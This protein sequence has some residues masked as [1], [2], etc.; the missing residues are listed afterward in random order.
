MT[1]LLESFKLG[2]IGHQGD[3]CPFCPPPDK[4]DHY[5]TYAGDK[6]NGGTLG[7]LLDESETLGVGGTIETEARPKDRKIGKDG[8]RNQYPRKTETQTEV[9]GSDKKWSFQAHHAIP[10]KQCLAKSPV[11]NFILE[12][13]RIRYDTG[14]SVN[15][16]QN[17]I[18]LPSMPLNMP[19]PDRNDPQGKFDLAQEAMAKFDRQF[20]LGHHAINVDVD[21]LD[22]DT[23]DVY[24]DYVDSFLI[25]LNSILLEW[26]G[27]CPEWKKKSDKPMGTP[28]IHSALD[29]VAEHLIK[30]LKGSPKRWSIFVSRHARDRT[31]KARD[32]SCK[33]DFE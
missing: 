24:T 28:R 16:P 12:G 26:K 11:Q 1:E 17:G 3:K 25:N 33:L 9:K 18:W 31:I 30:K 4:E 6:N 15:N 2:T 32:P 20:H 5:R 14:Y 10:G 23:V 27:A 13:I 29:A 21:G 19:W 7:S 8:A 22:T